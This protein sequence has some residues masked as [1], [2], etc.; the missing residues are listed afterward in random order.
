M[1]RPR[2]QAGPTPS[3]RAGRT[4]AK[5]NAAA[6]ITLEVPAQLI[7][8][9]AQQVAEQLG[10]SPLGD[11]SPWLTVDEAAEYL[12]C[13]KQAV[14]DRVHQNA[15]QPGRDGRRLLFHRDTLDAYLRGDAA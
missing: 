3:R 1:R 9:L 2:W 14:Y 10:V 11:T 8:A 15:L 6:G 5:D 12:R 7:A 13:S 4:M